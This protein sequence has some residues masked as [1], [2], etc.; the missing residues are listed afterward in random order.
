[1]IRKS[2][3]NIEIKSKFRRVYKSSL[4]I[5]TNHYLVSAQRFVDDL[6]NNLGEVE[7]FFDQS[8]IIFPTRSHY[9]L[10]ERLGVVRHVLSVTYRQKMHLRS[11]KGRLKGDVIWHYLLASKSMIPMSFQ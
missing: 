10:M 2:K 11:R 5:G 7:N 8:L 6:V 1:M 9:G 4:V 3:V